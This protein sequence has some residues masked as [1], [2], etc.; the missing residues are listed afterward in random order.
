MGIRGTVRKSSENRKAESFY[1]I[2]YQTGRASICT[3]LREWEG[4]GREE[5]SGLSVEGGRGG[6]E[7]SGWHTVVRQKCRVTAAR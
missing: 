7:I 2:V 1:Q 4:N 6:E 3:S 5:Q